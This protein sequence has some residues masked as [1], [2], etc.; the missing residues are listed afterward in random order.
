MKDVRIFTSFI[1]Y[2]IGNSRKIIDDTSILLVSQHWS[3]IKL[4][5]S[6]HIRE[7]N[8]PIRPDPF[9]ATVRVRGIVYS[10]SLSTTTWN[11]SLFDRLMVGDLR[12]CWQMI[13]PHIKCRCW[14]MIIRPH[15]KC[16]AMR[17][18]DCGVISLWH[19]I[20]W[21]EHDWWNVNYRIF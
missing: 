21:V 19:Y 4:T 13:W 8:R 1:A 17:I 5:R 9:C 16:N 6:W 2:R 14:W 18:W 12:C 7:W 11:I 15:M 20:L 3:I 10:W